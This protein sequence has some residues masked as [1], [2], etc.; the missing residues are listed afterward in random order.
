MTTKPEPVGWWCE[1]CENVSGEL[2]ET[3]LSKSWAPSN[4]CHAK[5]EPTYTRTQVR[6]GFEEL[7]G[8]LSVMLGYN[9]GKLPFTVISGN[10][11]DVARV[12]LRNVIDEINRHMEEW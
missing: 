10:T 1:D 12:V 6:K 5:G 7:A 3:E 4:T 11:D 9:N 2:H 8:K